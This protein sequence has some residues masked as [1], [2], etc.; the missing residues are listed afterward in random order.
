MHHELFG[1]NV[2]KI[3]MTIDLKTRLSSYNTGFPFEQCKY[4]YTKDVGDL[5]LR[6]VEKEI[7]KEMIQERIGKKE[8]FRIDL[9]E[10]ISVIENVCN[11]K[12]QKNEK[13]TC[14]EIKLE[15]KLQHGEDKC[16]TEMILSKLDDIDDDE[17]NVEQDLRISHKNECTICN[18]R[19]KYNWELQRHYKSIKKCTKQ[20]DESALNR[21]ETNKCTYCEK[22]FLNMWQLQKHNSKYSCEFCNMCFA[23]ESSAI[24]H[25]HICKSKTDIICIIERQLGIVPELYDNKKCRFCKF[26]FTTSSSNS[27]HKRIGCIEKHNYKIKLENMIEERHL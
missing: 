10:A 25:K 7:H 20:F 26:A 3:G 14:N 6:D 4:V 9:N 8:F 22:Q 2:Y 24:K 16:D 27:R 5:K 11:D 17:D 18:K 23:F 15:S 13:Y 21:N 1:E 19:F 12:K